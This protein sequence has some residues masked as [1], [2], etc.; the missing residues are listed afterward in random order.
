M[1]INTRYIPK[2]KIRKKGL[3]SQQTLFTATLD[4]LFFQ[5]SGFE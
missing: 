1:H 4:E 5:L 2:G 3:S